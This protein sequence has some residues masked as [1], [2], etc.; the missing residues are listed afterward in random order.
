MPKWTAATAPSK[1]G[2]I[3]SRRHCGRRTS[4]P[5]LTQDGVSG[6]RTSLPQDGDST[7][8]LPQTKRSVHDE[9]MHAPVSSPQAFT[10]HDILLATRMWM[11][12]RRHS[13][14][15]HSSPASSISGGAIPHSSPASS[16]T[17]GTAPPLPRDQTPAPGRED[18]D[19]LL[20]MR[21]WMR[22][23]RRSPP[24]EPKLVSTF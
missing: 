16:I 4:L 17:T 14:I 13:A 24:S 7:C 18:H 8:R 5:H 2:D 20:A 1:Q 12:R 9:T 22:H 15:P 11:R 10:D 3:F 21:M 6:R 19:N 23:R